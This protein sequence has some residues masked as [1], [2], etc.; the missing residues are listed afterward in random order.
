M[1]PRRV[2]QLA[3]GARD[4]RDIDRALPGK[5]TLRRQLAA[6]CQFPG[7]DLRLQ[8]CGKLHIGRQALRKPLCGFRLGVFFI[9]SHTK[10]RCGLNCEPPN[11]AKPSNI[12]DFSLIAAFCRK[13]DGHSRARQNNL[14]A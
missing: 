8:L 12:V 1:V 13:G 4:G 14:C 9:D 11:P 10:I 2:L 7:A 6:G 3:I 5:I